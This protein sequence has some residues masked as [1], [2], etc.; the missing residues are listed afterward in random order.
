M[1][2]NKDTKKQI[3]IYNILGHYISNIDSLVKYAKKKQDKVSSIS[4]TLI[5]LSTDSNYFLD[6]SLLETME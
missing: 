4:T 6:L 1:D 3:K 2:P 5:N